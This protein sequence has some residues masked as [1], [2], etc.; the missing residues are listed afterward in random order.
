MTGVWIIAHEC[1]HQAFSASQSLNNAVGLVLHSA[2]LVPYHSWRISHANH[3]K[4]TCSIED[5]E[6]CYFGGFSRRG[7][8]PRAYDLVVLVCVLHVLLFGFVCEC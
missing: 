3:H 8:V 1:G 2:L 7:F 5:D 4:Y 6:V